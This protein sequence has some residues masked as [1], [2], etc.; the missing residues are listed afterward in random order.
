MH[1]KIKCNPNL[2]KSLDR[3]RSSPDLQL[4]PTREKKK[5][6]TLYIYH[7][8]NNPVELLSFFRI[9]ALDLRGLGGVTSGSLNR[10][11]PIGAW[12]IISIF[13]ARGIS[14]DRKLVF[15]LFFTAYTLFVTNNND[16]IFL[17]NVGTCVLYC[18]L[19]FL[20]ATRFDKVCI[21][22]SL[23]MLG[24]RMEFMVI[25]GIFIF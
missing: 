14:F 10:A 19:I 4:D 5:G 13:V 16:L 2:E 15:S 25:F 21:W 11:A 8:Y 17:E 6:G 12:I 24:D 20:R 22:L 3:T 1:W 9:G 18:H 7:P 23:R